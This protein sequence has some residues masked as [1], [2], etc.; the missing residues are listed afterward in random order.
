MGA[1]DGSDVVASACGQEDAATLDAV[2]YGTGAGAP[3]GGGRRRHLCAVRV[4]A[5]EP[6]LAGVRAVHTV[7]IYEG[8]AL[9]L[10]IVRL[11]RRPH[12]GGVP[13]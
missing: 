10:A 12:A 13:S 7:P 11:D 1:A 9:P 3:I 8:Y 2:T 6:L 5:W 4:I